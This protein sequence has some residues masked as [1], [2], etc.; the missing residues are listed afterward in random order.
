MPV[1]YICQGQETPVNIQIWQEF[2]L[3]DKLV[4][5][6]MPVLVTCKFEEDPIKSESLKAYAIANIYSIINL[7]EI[8]CR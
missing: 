5:D 3:S 1:H 6:F 8:F 2:E 4:G 7:W